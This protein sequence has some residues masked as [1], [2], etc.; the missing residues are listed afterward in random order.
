MSDIF[1][2]HAEE[3][4]STALEITKALEH[5]GYSTWNYRQ[6]SIPGVE[7][8]HQVS[9]AIDDCQA[10]V[11]VI[12][13]ASLGSQQVHNEVVHAY[14]ERKRFI[15]V[16][17]DVTHAQFQKRQPVWR[18]ALGAATSITIPPE[19]VRTIMPRIVEGLE[20]SKVEPGGPEPD[21]EEPA[22][23]PAQ[24]TVHR[25]RVLVRAGATLAAIAVVV[26]VALVVVRTLREREMAA[27]AERITAA[28]NEGAWN[29][30]V[31]AT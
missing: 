4:A 7:Y 15:P 30:A 14:E 29:R 24:A 2:S 25:P 23:P 1:V 6:H 26:V 16:L 9:D 8:L 19:G 3:D 13:A 31:S 20:A 21:Q 28:M 12:S 11:L 22:E 5:A 18:Q 27:T 10:I 17:V